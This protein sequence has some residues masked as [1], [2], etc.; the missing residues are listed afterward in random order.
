MTIEEQIEDHNER[1]YDGLMTAHQKQVL[2][3]M[4]E[5]ED[6]FWVLEAKDFIKGYDDGEAQ[7]SVD[8]NH[9]HGEER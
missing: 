6:R 2:R 4:L 1:V 3:D 7:T 5:K 8:Q 9:Y